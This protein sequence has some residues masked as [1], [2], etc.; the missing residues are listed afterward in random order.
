MP[1]LFDDI[2]QPQ[3]QAAPAK[4]G[5]FADILAA[6][7]Q[8]KPGMMA[9]LG[10]S[11]GGGLVS[12][13]VGM[14]S[15]PADMGRLA[16]IGGMKGASY[17][18]RLAGFEDSANATDAELAKAM[19]AMD[20]AGKLNVGGVPILPGLRSSEQNKDAVSSVAPSFADPN[21]KPE[22]TAG[23]YVKTTAEL[24]PAAIGGPGGLIRR[25]VGT[26]LGGALSETA[27]HALEGSAWEGPAR[28]VGA[29]VGMGAPS[30]VRMSPSTAV[31]R[32]M[33]GLNQADVAAAEAVMRNAAEQG[34]RLSWDE[35]L[36]Q[37]TNGRGQ[38]TALRRVVENSEGGAPLKDMM[39]GRPAEV[40]TAGRS[41]INQ[42][43][44]ANPAPS[45]IGP[46]VGNAAAG[47]VNEVKGAISKAVEPDYA[48]ALSGIPADNP[49]LMEIANRPTVAKALEKADVAAADQ[50]KAYPKMIVD[51][52]GREVSPAVPQAIEKETARLASRQYAD[53]ILSKSFGTR[54]PLATADKVMAE[55]KAA[56]D[57]LYKAAREAEIPN[58]AIPVDLLTRLKE[59]GAYGAAV[60]TMRVEGKPFDIGKIEPWDYMKQALDDRISAAK[61][62]GQNNAARVLTNLKNE[63]TASVD[64]AI[65]VYAQARKAF[66]GPS[67]MLKA[68][69]RG[70]EVWSHG[71]TREM[72]QREIAALETQ[73]EKE[74]YRLGAG[75]AKREQLANLGDKSNFSASAFGNE[76]DR[77]KMDVIAPGWQK[78]QGKGLAIPDAEFTEAVKPNTPRLKAGLDIL[79]G[80]KDPAAQP[81]LQEFMRNPDF[82]AARSTEGALRQKYLQ[83]LLDG[84][85]GKLAG[86]KS[87]QQAIEALFPSN[88]LPAS[89]KEVQTAVSAVARRNPN[90]ARDLVRA[91]VESVFNE[92]TKDLQAGANPKGGANF[93]KNLVGNTQQGANLEVAVKALPGGDKVWNGFTRLFETLE[94]TGKAPNM[95]S[96]TAPDLG[97]RKLLQ[98][99]HGVEALLKFGQVTKDAVERARLG[100][101]I[102]VVADILTNPRSAGLL[103]ELAR[104]PRGS[105][106]ALVIAG[107]IL[108]RSNAAQSRSNPVNQ[109]E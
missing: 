95:G 99:G 70:K 84:P 25:G 51:Q 43:G 103:G 102:S 22:T 16:M 44:P 7:P 69:E 85:L 80:A 92:A 97:T 107:R 41:A 90:A 46:D 40:E 96:N 36:A 79:E 30:M 78:N 60:K 63:L 2:L 8:E 104:A 28:A 88:P 75:A 98:E 27:G 10:K 47:T 49:S 57:P 61:S 64:E 83:P 14:A 52:T 20:A 5:L 50:G 24:A 86:E 21:Y 3:Q 54:D 34:V 91:H 109:A 42:V 87:T 32:A 39:A 82:A 31:E 94:A 56:A 35:A 101:N 13:V 93:V 9:D 68:L 105:S 38:M 29:V 71:V 53:D 6:Q 48:K 81:L 1:G 37:A 15:M 65:P 77:A 55:R 108:A 18:K 12:G 66:A 73:G 26:A 106:K 59:A 23:R 67:A 33:S 100:R 89:E 19:T 4:G 74:M 58:E 76:A 72:V 62:K 45:S 17:L 11:A